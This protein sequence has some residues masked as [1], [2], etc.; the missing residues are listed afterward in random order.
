VC[1]SSP[2]EPW[3]R[4]LAVA[5]GIRQHVDVG[6][7]IRVLSYEQA[8]AEDVERRAALS[9]AERVERVPLLLQGCLAARE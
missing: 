4:G 1:R 5:K 3:Q 2:F 8:E 9:P 7:S 6:R